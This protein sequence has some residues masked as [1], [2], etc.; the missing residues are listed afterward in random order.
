MRAADRVV[1]EKKSAAVIVWSETMFAKFSAQTRTCW[2]SC[3]WQKFRDLSPCTALSSSNTSEYGTSEKWWRGVHHGSCDVCACGDRTSDRWDHLWSASVSFDEA[4]DDI[5]TGNSAN[6]GAVS[7]EAGHK[8]RWFEGFDWTCTST[9]TL[10]CW[11]GD[12][13]TMAAN[14]NFFGMTEVYI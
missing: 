2:A 1:A 3:V 8:P 13:A 4:D 6:V 12:P 11:N 7:V 10:G 5:V 14:F 9:V